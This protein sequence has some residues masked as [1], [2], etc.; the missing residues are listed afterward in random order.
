MDTD[1]GAVTRR[2]LAVLVNSGSASASE[3]LS[4]ALHDN[5]RAVIVGDGNT[6]GKGRI[7]SVFELEV[8][9]GRGLSSRCAQAGR[10]LALRPLHG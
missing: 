6:Y 2:P 8:R 5:N 4:G 10:S 7:Q 9:R 3:I 1:G